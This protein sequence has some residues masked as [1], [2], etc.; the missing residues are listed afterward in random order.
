MSLILTKSQQELIR[1]ENIKTFDDL[2]AACFMFMPST[3]QSQCLG[4]CEFNYFYHSND[5]FSIEVHLFNNLISAEIT[6]DFV[7]ID[8]KSNAAMEIWLKNGHMENYNLL[9]TASDCV[10]SI[11]FIVYQFLLKN[12]QKAKNKENN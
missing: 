3:R 1:P 8:G 4:A 6:S 7:T 11:R 5:D 2:I 10:A 9:D 12:E